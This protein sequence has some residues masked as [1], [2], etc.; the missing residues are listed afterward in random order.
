MDGEREPLCL[1][2]AERWKRIHNQPDWPIHPEA[3]E[4]AAE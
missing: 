1:S 3:Y 4:P 2:C